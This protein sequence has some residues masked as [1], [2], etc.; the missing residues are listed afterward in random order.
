MNDKKAASEAGFTII[1]LLVAISVA[2]MI[3]FIAVGFVSNS[4]SN[5]NRET[6]TVSSQQ[7]LRRVITFM[8]GKILPAKTLRVLPS[9]ASTSEV[10]INTVGRI[11]EITNYDGGKYVFYF[12]T[13]TKFIMFKNVTPNVTL[14]VS[15]KVFDFTVTKVDA[16]NIRVKIQA[17][18]AGKYS[19]N[20]YFTP[21]NSP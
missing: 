3:I 6:T 21:R 20:T 4:F 14:P 10:S 16:K 8:S 9:I 18:S 15:S 12:D 19:I 5:F 11:L 17:D 13:A 2:S 1:E 7:D